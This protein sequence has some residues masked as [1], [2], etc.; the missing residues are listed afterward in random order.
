[1]LLILAYVGLFS[2]FRHKL[3]FTPDFGESDAYHFNLSL[4]YFLADSLKHNRLPFWTDLLQGGFPLLAEGQIGALFLPNLVF[5]KFINFIDAYNLLFVFSLFSLSLGT[6]LFLTELELSH[7]IS[8]LFS[9]LISFSGI[10]TLHLTHLN[11]IQTFSLTPLLFY[12]SLAYFNSQKKRYLFFIP[13]II[14][15][16][17]F[18]GHFQTVFI[19]LLGFFCWLLLYLFI[20]KYNKRRFVKNVLLFILLGLS[21]VV[22]ALPQLWPTYILSLFSSR[23]LG[24]DFPLA[25]SFPLPFKHLA[26]FVYPFAFGNPKTATY[27]LFSGSW[28]IF[29]ENTPYM[30]WLLFIIFTISV[31]IVVWKRKLPRLAYIYAAL[32]VFFVL[33]ALGKN[34]PLYFVYDFVPFNLFRTPSK[35]LL[36]ASFFLLLLM[37]NCID[38]VYRLIKAKIVRLCILFFLLVNLVLLVH[39]AYTYHLFADAS[40]VLSPPKLAQYINQ[41]MYVT[42]GQAEIWNEIFLHDGW[43]KPKDV[44]N[45]LFLKNFLYPNA[46]LLTGEPSFLINTGGFT[47]KRVD[48]ITDLYFRY[49]SQMDKTLDASPEAVQLANIINMPTIVSAYPV[50][51]NDYTLIGKVNQNKINVFIYQ[52]KSIKDQF[53]Y[54]PHSLKKITYVSDFDDYL[55]NGKLSTEQSMIETS[56]NVDMINNP[57]GYKILSSSQDLYH[58]TLKG[59]FPED[60]YVVLRLNLYPDWKIL[61]DGKQSHIYPINLVHIG[62]KIPKGTHILK[63]V[64]RNDSFNSGVIVATVYLVVFVFFLWKVKK[65]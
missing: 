53:F 14:T 27:P 19:S 46:N 20:K 58:R 23:G 7:S 62:V 17:I 41:S 47:L 29:W 4:K 36:M 51:N 18:A 3:L 49:V 5:L 1:M 12:F 35:Y 30:G 56:A 13:F 54:I 9:L 28:G 11:L 65:P 55:Q 45:Y 61:V 8:F 52:D 40:A 63:V 44:E 34:S 22:F 25:T 10:V 48:H 43:S 39:F 37:A 38:Y 59:I 50:K 64:Y 31:I 32:F 57:S 24:L 6:Y 26:A 42:F 60:T 21:G 2:I 15:Q 16:M 33:L